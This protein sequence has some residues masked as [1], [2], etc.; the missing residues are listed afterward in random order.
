MGVNGPVTLTG[1]LICDTAEQAMRVRDAVDTHIALT[2]AEAGCIYFNVD[3]T[4]DPLVWDVSEQFVDADAFEV[5]QTRTRASY[6]AQQTAGI[7]RD[8]QISGR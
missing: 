6:W 3:A 4:G 8:F 1:K 2:R 7:T 5:H